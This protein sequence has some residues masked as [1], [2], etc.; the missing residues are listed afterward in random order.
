VCVCVCAVLTVVWFCHP[1]FKR[2]ASLVSINC[3]FL[4]LPSFGVSI[5]PPFDFVLSF[6]FSFFLPGRHTLPLP[7]SSFSWL[8]SLKAHVNDSLFSLSGEVFVCLLLFC[9]WKEKRVF[10]LFF[11]SADIPSS[12]FF[13]AVFVFA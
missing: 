8:W 6:F 10:L 7:L 3:I 1:L 11:C 5:Y 2:F 9:V 12:P 13:A 4:F